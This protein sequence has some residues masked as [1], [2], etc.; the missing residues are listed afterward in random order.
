MEQAF[1]EAAL[2][3]GNGL[4]DGRFGEV[5]LGSGAGEGA[6]FG[7]F[8]EDGP[9]FEVGELRHRFWKRCVSRGSIFKSAARPILS[10]SMSEIAQLEV[11]T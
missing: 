3:T 7:N 11:V 6:G 9:G 2:E 10:T 5:E 1:A 8:G 4:G